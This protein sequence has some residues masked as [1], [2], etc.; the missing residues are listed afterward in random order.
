MDDRDIKNTLCDLADTLKKA[1][2]DARD[3]TIRNAIDACEKANYSSMR[4]LTRLIIMAESYIEMMKEPS[5]ISDSITFS[6]GLFVMDNTLHTLIHAL[7]HI[8]RLV[9]IHS[10][11]E[12]IKS[13]NPLITPERAIEMLKREYPDIQM[14]SDFGN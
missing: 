8:P 13:E 10:R 4:E 11:I 1:S 5:V 14:T 3:R 12:Q 7:Q 2:D 9:E 6:L